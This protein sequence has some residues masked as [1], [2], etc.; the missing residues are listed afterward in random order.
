[1][2]LVSTIS[3]SLM[4]GFFPAGWDLT[5]IDACVDSDPQTITNRQSWWHAEFEPTACPW[6]T[7]FDMMFGHE[8]ALTMRRWRDSGEKLGLIL[9]VGAMGMYRGG[10][11]FLTASRVPCVH[12]AVFNMA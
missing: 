11:E 10:G 8:I 12:V 7:D 5:R 3:G 2:D 6:L 1:M 4:E 9:P